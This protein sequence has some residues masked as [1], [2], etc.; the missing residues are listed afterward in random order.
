MIKNE[1]EYKSTK[2]AIAAYQDALSNFSI[3]RSIE[4]GV[5]PIIA[6]AQ[7]ASY[8]R[9][10][11]ELQEQVSAYEALKSGEQTQLVADEILQVGQKLIAARV[12][13]GLTQREFAGLAGLKEQQIQRYEKEAYSSANLKR[14]SFLASVLD[15]RFTAEIRVNTSDRETASDF[16][17]SLN[18][19][20]YP[21]S[22]MNKWNWFDRRLDLRR[23]SR[24]EKRRSLA[25][26]FSQSGIVEPTPA[27]HRKSKGKMSAARRGALLAWQARVLSK[28]R[29]KAALARRFTPLPPEAIK[30]LIE[31]SRA[32]D[33]PVRVVEFLLGFGIIVVFE[34]HLP[35]T[36]LDGAA[37]NLDGKYAVIGL[38]ARHDRIDN[39]WF[40]LLHELGHVMRHW[41]PMLRQGFVDEEGDDISDALELEADE[42]AQNSIVS[43]EDWHSSFIRFSQSAEEIIEFAE[44]RGI[45]PALVAGRI[46]RERQSYREFADLLGQ[47]Q[48][49]S[50][51]ESTGLLEKH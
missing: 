38:T 34:K 25:A 49:R 43:R 20:D 41:G 23:T 16:L 48:V 42:F 2:A 46:R 18:P 37:M 40:S 35:G 4:Q 22:E 36:K 6:K 15:V 8:E 12:A 31:F 29:S 51:L 50:V 32:P 39:F 30:T 17:Q 24:E 28:A 45:H 11:N 10:I 1:K 21:I 5:D 7:R 26:F 14:L 47:G 44:R 33:G 19:D 27:L 13:M 9:Q 3:L